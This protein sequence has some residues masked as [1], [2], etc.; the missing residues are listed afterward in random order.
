VLAVCLLAA[1][2][3]QKTAAMLEMG[4]RAVRAAACWA[5]RHPGALAVAGGCGLAVGLGAYLAGPLV[6]SAALG[7]AGA[8]ASLA[9]WVLAP[10]LRLFRL[11]EP[12]RYQA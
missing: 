1:L 9:A 3:A 5:W 7:L 12:P 2:L 11:F 8:L 4:Y 6:S 10:L